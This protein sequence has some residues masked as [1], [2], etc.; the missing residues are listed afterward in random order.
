MLDYKK[1]HSVIE[2]LDSTF[3]LKKDIATG[4]R[5]CK[6][7]GDRILRGQHCLVYSGKAFKW[8]NNSVKF[9][10][11]NQC[12]SDYL[13]SIMDKCNDLLESMKLKRVK[14]IGIN[15]RYNMINQ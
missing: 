6:V 14:F 4:H 10:V 8:P 7:C 9:S 3:V 1:K 13:N 2:L 12:S 11:C 15:K 5:K